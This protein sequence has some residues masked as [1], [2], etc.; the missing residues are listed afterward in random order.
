MADEIDE[1]EAERLRRQKLVKCLREREARTPRY[2]VNEDELREKRM[3]DRDRQGEQIDRAAETARVW[4]WLEQ[5]K[6]FDGRRSVSA[7][8]EPALE[9]FDHSWV[10]RHVA[11]CLVREREYFEARLAELNGALVD[12]ARATAAAF[13]AIDAALDRAADKGNKQL[14]GALD[15]I[16]KQLSEN[17]RAV[18]R[19]VSAKPV[20]GTLGERSKTLE[21]LED[22][23]S[24]KV[25]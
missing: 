12:N 8:A 1:A 10:Q 2:C 16:S 25:H 22:P 11:A 6:Q 20:V 23:K 14:T 13:D 4:N 5:Q 3:Q 15:R 21:K 17:Q 9:V 19:A 24:A 7:A 18:L